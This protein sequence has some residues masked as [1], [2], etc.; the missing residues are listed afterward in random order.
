MGRGQKPVDELFVGQ[1]IAVAHKLFDLVR[2]RWKSDEIER[3]A[4][5]QRAAIGL[6]RGFQSHRAETLPDEMR[7]LAFAPASGRTL[8]SRGRS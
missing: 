6:G 4:A 5:N 7:R 3:E 1:R 2:L 8:P